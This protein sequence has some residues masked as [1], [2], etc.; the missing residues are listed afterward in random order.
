M[1]DW[2][3]IDDCI[4]G[5]VLAG[6]VGFSDMVYYIGSRIRRPLKEIVEELRDILAPEA[7]I[8]YGRYRDDFHMEYQ[9]IDVHLLYKHTGYLAK[10]DFKDAVM[11]T[12]EWLK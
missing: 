7:K 12:A 6:E 2:V 4:R 1:Y 3:Y 11:K 8:N 10:T 9:F 5:L